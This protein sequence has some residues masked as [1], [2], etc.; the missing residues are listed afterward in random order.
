MKNAAIF[1]T[2]AAFGAVGITVFTVSALGIGMLVLAKE[3]RDD[4]NPF[5]PLIIDEEEK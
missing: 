3:I 4:N 2:G 1:A 5:V